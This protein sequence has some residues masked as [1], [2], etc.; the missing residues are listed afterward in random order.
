MKLHKNEILQQIWNKNPNAANVYLETRWMILVK[1]HIP[2]FIQVSVSHMYTAKP[3]HQL[4]DKY[5]RTMQYYVDI[6]SNMAVLSNRLTIKKS[7]WWIEGEI[8]YFLTCT[9]I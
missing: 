7:S 4:C 2:A 3:F 9:M 5:Y 6:W 8:V 1:L